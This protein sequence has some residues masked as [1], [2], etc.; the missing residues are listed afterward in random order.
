MT[1]PSPSPNG[2]RPNLPWKTRISLFFLTTFTDA[3]TRPD[4]TVNRRIF[5]LLES[6][7]L[8][9]PPNP[10]HREVK[11]SDVTLDPSRNLWFRLFIPTRSESDP[12][13]PV[14]VFFHGGGFVYLA[15]DFKPY[16]NVCRRFASEFPAIVVSVN[17][18]LAPEHR[19]PAPYEDG[20]DA[21]RFLDEQRHILPENADL[22]RCFVVGDS[23]GANLAHHVATRACDS[24]FN[25]LKVI[26]VV[27]IQPFFG[28]EER[29]K[30]EIE[31]VGV[32][33]IV[34][35]SRTDFMWNAFIQPGSGMDRDHEVINV[36]GPKA[37]DISKLDFPP[38]MVVVAGF[39][40]LKDWQTRYYEWLKNNGKEAYLLEYPNMIHAFY[41]F[42]ELPEAGQLVSSIKQFVQDKCSKVVV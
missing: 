10:N 42:P 38:T 16:D 11:T 2:Q 24:K 13:L 23:A 29:T 27:A 40:S 18:R 32:D 8:K 35:A 17:Y 28:G 20:F 5:S 14:I 26:G 39:D 37:A 33:M 21:L 15:P 41:I 4:G 6:A 22:S 19:Y 31:L 30:S 34:S 9:T 7:G 25:H 36:S 12:R 3:S 1:S